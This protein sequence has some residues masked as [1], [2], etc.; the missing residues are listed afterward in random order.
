MPTIAE[1]LSI[2][3]KNS[4][5]SNLL[6]KDKFEIISAK[7]YNA[8]GDGVSDDSDYILDGLAYIRAEGLGSYFFPHGIYKVDPARFDSNTFDGIYLWGDNSS[9]D[10]IS[11]TIYQVGVAVVTPDSVLTTSILNKAVTSP[12]LADDIQVGS[13]AL[14][15]ALITG[16]A[17]ASVTAA[18]NAVVSLLS[19]DIVATQA[20]AYTYA[21]TATENDTYVVTLS[22]V[23]EAYVEGMTLN[24]K[25]DVGNTGD[26]TLNANSK[27]AIALAKMTSTGVASLATGDM[28]ANGTYTVIYTTISATPYFLVMNPTGQNI[29]TSI[30]T[31]RGM[32]IRSSGANAPEAVA[33]GM[34]NKALVSDGTDIVYGYP[35]MPLYSASNNQIMA[36][37]SEL[38]C[39]SS[40]AYQTM[41]SFVCKY[42]GEVRVNCDIKSGGNNCT[43]LVAIAPHNVSV[44]ES[45][46][47]GTG[48]GN[49]ESV[50]TDVY[51]SAGQRYAIMCKITV[52]TG[53]I[54]NIAIC[55]DKSTSALGN[56]IF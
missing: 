25:V 29:P 36:A 28:V 5:L 52:A 27:G 54:K 49:Y 6:E 33:L 7:T 20:G 17:R 31:A 13:L 42:S 14:L 41:M 35:D 15:S 26:A 56:S 51:V 43:L 45:N 47:S 40:A 24:I 21:T 12:K 2:L 48:T 23:P 3:T 4:E 50:T 44:P 8:V 19:A 16:T 53:Y 34:A 32:F 22:P 55:A 10:G 39:N 11:D 30:L 18:I 46:F 37:A 9:F 38:S 1:T